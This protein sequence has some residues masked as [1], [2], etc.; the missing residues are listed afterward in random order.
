MEYVLEKVQCLKEYFEKESVRFSEFENLKWH[1]RDSFGNIEKSDTLDWE[2]EEFEEFLQSSI[3]LREFPEKLL[4]KKFRDLLQP[5]IFQKGKKTI[6]CKFQGKSED[7]YL[8]SACTPEMLKVDQAFFMERARCSVLDV[9]YKPYFYELAIKKTGND[10]E[11]KEGQWYEI[12][13]IKI[14]KKNQK[15]GIENDLDKMQREDDENADEGR[16]SENND[17][18]CIGYLT[19]LAS[20]PASEAVYIK[21]KNGIKEIDKGLPDEIVINKA[22]IKTDIDRVKREMHT[23]FKDDIKTLKICRV[24]QANFIHGSNGTKEFVFDIGF[25]ASSYLEYKAETGAI[26]MEKSWIFDAADYGSFRNLKLIMISHWHQDHYKGAYLLERDKYWKNAAP[27]WITQI[28]DDLQEKDY[29]ACRLVKYLLKIDKIVFMPENGSYVRGN[30]KLCCSVWD[31]TSDKENNYRS[32]LL[33]LNKTLLPGDCVCES[34]P[35][36][37]PTLSEVYYMTVP[38]HGS[39]YF[40]EE[41]AA[42]K[43]ESKTKDRCKAIICVGKS[44][45]HPSQKAEAFYPGNRMKCIAVIQTKNAKALSDIC[46]MDP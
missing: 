25:P 16:N 37:Y 12:K 29:N 18:R 31:P 6:Y 41:I 7:F 32:L 42:Q 20:P 44:K 39:A 14:E 33:Q 2:R 30:Y 15:Q 45:Y 28:Y 23:V 19:Y 13:V 34:W 26:D 40:S 8:F 24:G 4:C 21:W 5:F 35:T 36:G 22:E 10:L 3:F 1:K 17:D 38:H 9:L 27:T 46:I 43:L 11:L